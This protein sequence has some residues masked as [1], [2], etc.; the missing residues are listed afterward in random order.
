MTETEELRR[1]RAENLVNARIAAG[2]GSALAASNAMGKVQSTYNNYERGKIRY[3][4]YAKEFAGFFGVS[5]EDLLNG[6]I[7]PTPIK[8]EIQSKPNQYSP[9]HIEDISIITRNS[10]MSLNGHSVFNESYFTIRNPDRAMTKPD[11]SALLQD[12]ILVFDSSAQIR[13][14]DFV[15]ARI[16]GEIDPVFRVFYPS[17]HG[18][19][20]YEALNPSIEKI[21]VGKGK[22]ENLARLRF[23]MKPIE[24]LG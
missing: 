5:V 1:K 24:S 7:E 23:V 2:Y 11:G 18:Q 14:A 16:H 15:L 10:L 9:I 19:A 8:K 12:D 21:A 17:N 13:P 20:I 22:W 6:T 3:A 4:K